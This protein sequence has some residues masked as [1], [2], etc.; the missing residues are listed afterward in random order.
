L[1]GRPFSENV[2]LKIGRE[3]QTRTDFHKRRPPA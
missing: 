2:L 3:F 1:A